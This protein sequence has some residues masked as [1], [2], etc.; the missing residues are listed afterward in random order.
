MNQNSNAVQAPPSPVHFFET[1]NAFQKTEA[2]KAAIELD[3]FTAIEEGKQ[4]SAE[5]AQRCKTS[6]RGM[7]ILCDFM[8]MNEFLTKAGNH[9]SL[10][11]DSGIFLSKRSP[12]YLG[13][14]ANFLLN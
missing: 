2:L 10:T 13:G 8:V 9:Y 4:T 5:I 11:R 1:I 14:A 6:E 3:V 7:R 12:A